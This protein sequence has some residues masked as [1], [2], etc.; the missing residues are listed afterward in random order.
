LKEELN[1]ESRFKTIKLPIK[2]I[3]ASLKDK[4]RHGVPQAFRVPIW[5]ASVTG[6]SLADCNSVAQTVTTSSGH[7]IPDLLNQFGLNDTAI[8]TTFEPT[9]LQLVLNAF[10]NTHPT[11]TSAPLIPLSASLLLEYFNPPLVL[12]II[13]AMLARG[14]FYFAAEELSFTASLQVIEA[15]I[16]RKCRRFVEWIDR[17][18]FGLTNV[19]LFLVQ[20][21]F[22]AIS[23]PAALTLFDIFLSEGQDFLNRLCV[24]LLRTLETRLIQ[25]ESLEDLRRVVFDFFGGLSEPR[26]LTSFLTAVFKVSLTHHV[27]TEMLQTCNTLTPLLMSSSVRTGQSS[28]AQS[29]PV[30]AVHTRPI[31]RCI[32]DVTITCGHLLS[33]QFLLEIRRALPRHMDRYTTA[34]LCYQM[35]VD[36]TALLTL[37]GRSATQGLWILLFQTKHRIVGAAFQGSLDMGLAKKGKFVN[38]GMVMVFAKEADDIKIYRNTMKNNKLYSVER[39]GITFGG[40][41]PALYLGTD[42]RNIYSAQCETF[43]SPPLV[44]DMHVG[45]AILDAELFQLVLNTE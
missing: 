43:D 21:F 10:L 20:N 8:L 34:A 18:S 41:R 13:E 16:C 28:Y 7:T 25:C 4:I 40:P 31:I 1:R 5:F 22:T 12:F 3:S 32:G 29:L 30:V 15:G 33:Q 42:F 23:R 2:T 11:I 45:D 37:L 24:C 44:D 19:L 36:G 39:S 17:M 35:S 27:C 6:T 9:I 14:S 26:S 38:Q